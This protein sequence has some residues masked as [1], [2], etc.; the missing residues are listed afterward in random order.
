MLEFA[1][2][3]LITLVTLLL[4]YIT[5]RSKLLPKNKRKKSKRKC[6]LSS[7]R[8]ENVYSDYEDTFS[9]LKKRDSR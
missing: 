2:V 6:K 7:I 1:I 8:E 5:C 9:C 3:F 4:V